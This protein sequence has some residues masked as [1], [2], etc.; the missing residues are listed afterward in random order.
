MTTW[1]EPGVSFHLRPS[2][3][4]GGKSSGLANGCRLAI[5]LS[6]SQLKYLPAGFHCTDMTNLV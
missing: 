1:V 5:K 4:S 3:I 6:V 2:R